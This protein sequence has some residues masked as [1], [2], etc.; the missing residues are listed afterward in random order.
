[1]ATEKPISAR[2]LTT[3]EFTQGAF[4]IGDGLLGK[5]AVLIIGGPP[6]SYKSF[7]INTLISHLTTA[8]PLFS[9]DRDS[10]V[11]FN[12]PNHNKVLLLEQEIGDYDL[13][14][15]L[16]LLAS[17]LPKSH[18]EQL[19]DNLF[20]KS[21]D[22]GMRLDSIGG[23]TYMAEMIHAV[24]P[25]VVILD[26]LIEF[27]DGDENSTKEMSHML[28]NLDWLRERLHFA[29]IIVHHTAK[30]TDLNQLRSG[31]DLLR[32]SSVIHAKADSFV[33]VQKLKDDPVPELRLQYTLRRGKPIP[34]MRVMG[35]MEDCLFRFKRWEADRDDPL[36]PTVGLLQ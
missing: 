16:L 31:P 26:P 15:R 5:Q 29:T 34:R 32:G 7:L 28:H 13:K 6:K 18:R 14:E 22:H 35:G 2:E 25:S 3:K 21:C 1:M 36:L 12:V 8:T 17:Q 10:H 19:M 9:A 24:E 11:Y 27:H 20:I 4:V 30:L 33:M 23:R